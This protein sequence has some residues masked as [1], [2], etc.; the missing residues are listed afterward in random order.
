MEDFKGKALESPSL[1]FLRLETLLVRVTA[2]T[3]PA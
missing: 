1:Y 2:M 3:Y